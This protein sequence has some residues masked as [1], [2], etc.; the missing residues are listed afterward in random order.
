MPD[1]READEPDPLE[2]ALLHNL[3]LITPEAREE[4]LALSEAYT[5]LFPLRSA[6][7]LVRTGG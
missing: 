3:R 6:L 5:E 1:N 4:L 2:T 7:H